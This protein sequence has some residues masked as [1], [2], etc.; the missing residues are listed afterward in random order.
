MNPFWLIRR[1]FTRARHGPGAEFPR[2]VDEHWYCGAWYEYLAKLRD[3]GAYTGTTMDPP[4]IA[5]PANGEFAF[6]PWHTGHAN[7]D[8]TG[9]IDGL[10]PA[11]RLGNRVGLYKQIGPRYRTTSF[12]DGLPWDDGYF[13]DLKFVRSIALTTPRGQSCKAAAKRQEAP[14]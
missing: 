4:E 2:T 10:V 3:Q 7:P 6:N 9:L 1:M 11:M 13:V 5:S 14:R 12:Y 8:T